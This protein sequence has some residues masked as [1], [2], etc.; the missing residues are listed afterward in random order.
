[1][2]NTVDFY[3]KLHAERKDTRKPYGTTGGRNGGPQVRDILNSYNGV[4]VQ[5]VLD[6]GCGS[7]TLVKMLK[8]EVRPKLR[9]Y[10]YDPAIPGKDRPPEEQFDMVV[11]TDVLEHIPPDDLDDV[12]AHIF[13]LARRSVYLLI[14]CDPCGITMDDGRNAHLIQEGYEWWAGKLDRDGWQLMYGADVVKRKR[15]GLRRHVEFHLE[16]KG[17]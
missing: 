9:Y 2:S 11:S 14:A 8:E 1:M 13:R 7:G 15:S 5:S 16:K 6:Y 3:K 12:L 10:E 17:A 4:W